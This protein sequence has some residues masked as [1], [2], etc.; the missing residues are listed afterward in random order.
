MEF[1][2]VDKKGTLFVLS[3]PSGA[4]KGTLRERLFENVTGITFSISCTTRTPRHG[5]IDGKDYRFIGKNE[6]L[7]LV[8]EGAFLEWAEVHG[9]YYGTLIKDVM[10]DL[11]S[12]KS[13][14]L[15]IDVQGARQIKQKYPQAIMI[16]VVPPSLEELEKR[17]RNRATEGERDLGVRLSNAKKEIEDACYYDHIIVNDGL[18]GASDEL[19]RLVR[20]YSTQEIKK[21]G[22]Y[23][24]IL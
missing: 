22:S 14:V 6:F 4:G 20:Y 11:S 10:S 9:N 17:L 12:G 13:V 3:G 2:K 15:E 21:G 19:I 16:F 23:N 18:S 24:E 1:I 8:D 7:K 5:E